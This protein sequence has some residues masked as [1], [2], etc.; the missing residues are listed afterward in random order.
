MLVKPRSL[1]DVKA[2]LSGNFNPDSL[3][4]VFILKSWLV[5]III[6][7]IFVGQADIMT[8]DFADL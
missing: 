3:S 8:D 7:R 4:T 5:I 6:D 1:H 2:L